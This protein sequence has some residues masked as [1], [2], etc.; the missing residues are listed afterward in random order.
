M[1]KVLKKR[2]TNLGGFL[3]LTREQADNIRFPCC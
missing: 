3:R 2:L 1:M